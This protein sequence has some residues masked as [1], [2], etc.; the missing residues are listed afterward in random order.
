MTQM[1]Q[2]HLN[3]IKSKFIVHFKAIYTGVLAENKEMFIF[4]PVLLHTHDRQI[5]NLFYSCLL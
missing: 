4:L 2:L 1:S 3:K 5:S